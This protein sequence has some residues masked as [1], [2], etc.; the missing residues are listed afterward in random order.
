MTWLARFRAPSRRRS[1]PTPPRKYR[2]A[3][4]VLEDRIVPSGDPSLSLVLAAHTIAENAGPAATTATVTRNN[5]D[6]SSPEARIASLPQV[7]PMARSAWAYHAPST[8]RLSAA[9]SQPKRNALA[10]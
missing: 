1:T 8:T 3:A 9:A 4:E 6:T 5:M 10:A 7:G 2:P